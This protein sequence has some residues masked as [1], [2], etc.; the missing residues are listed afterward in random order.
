MLS[1]VG[2]AVVLVCV[3]GGYILAGGKIGII[4]EALPFELLIIGGAAVGSFLIANGGDVLGRTAKSIGRIVSGPRW[5]RSD[6]RDLLCLLFILTKLIRSKGMLAVEAHIERPQDSA[7]FQRYPRILAD[8]FAVTFLCDYLRMMS[9]DLDDPHHVD[10]V[11]EGELER[12]HHDALRPAHALQAMADGLPALGIVAAVMGVIKTMASISEPPEVL[13]GM[14]GGAL[15]GTFLG[16]L[17]SYGAV[18]PLAAR[19]KQI[20]DEDARFY[21]V[22][23][24]TITAFLHGSMPQVAVEVGR[25]TVPARSLPSFHDIDEAIA[26]LPAA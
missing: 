13:G 25:K 19:L 20:E 26:E 8:S 24:D 18:G 10:E 12:H 2:I 5:T 6:Y 21:G 11:M 7:L 16:V 1:L 9:L 14:I 3:F 23:R 4:A 15:V 17:L 22:M